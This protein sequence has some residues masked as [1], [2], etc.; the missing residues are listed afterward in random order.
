MFHLPAT[1]FTAWFDSLATSGPG[2]YSLFLD[3]LAVDTTLAAIRWFLVQEA[4]DEAVFFG[5][6]TYRFARFIRQE[7]Q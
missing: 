7:L 4:A 5:P 3:W 6:D 2:Q 1:Y